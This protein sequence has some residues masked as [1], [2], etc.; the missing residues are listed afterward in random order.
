MKSEFTVSSKKKLSKGYKFD[1]FTNM[2][3]NQ[4]ILL[5][6][7]LIFLS[8]ISYLKVDAYTSIIYVNLNAKGL[9]NGK[10]WNDAFSDLQSALEKAESGDEIWVAAGVYKPT[11]SR[12][13]TL[14]FELENGVSIFGGFP[15]EGGDWD[16]RNWQQN[17]T[18]L[19]GD[20]GQTGNVSDNSYHVVTGNAS[21]DNSSILDGFTITSGNA[22]SDYPDNLGGGMYNTEGSPIL[23]N[24][25]FSENYAIHG[26]GMYNRKSE[27]IILENITFDSNAA[28]ERGG[29]IYNYSSRATLSGVLFKKNNAEELGG[30]MNNYDSHITLTDVDFIEN[31][32]LD[33]GGGVYSYATNIT[34]NRAN[35]LGNTAESGGGMMNSA[36]SNAVV[37]H[38]TFENNHA[39]ERAG[40][41]Y[42]YKSDPSFS[43]TTFKGNTAL[44]FGGGAMFNSASNTELTNVSFT[45]NSTDLYGGAIINSGG[46]PKLTNVSF[47][48]NSAQRGGGMYN[49]DRSKPIL[50]NV[51]FSMNTADSRGGG[52]YSADD[53][54]DFKLTDVTFSQNFAGEDG[55]G[56]FMGGSSPI[57]THVTFTENTSALHGGGFYNSGGS[58]TL[59][60][61]TFIDNKAVNGGGMNNRNGTPTLTDVTFS[62]NTAQERGGGIYN[63]LGSPKLS[64]INLTENY[65]GELGG[66]MFSSE[67]T[68][69]LFNVQISD[70]NAGSFGGG[71]Y[72]GGS[73]AIL[74]NITLS[75]NSAQERGGAI[76]NNGSDPNLTNVTISANAS[77]IGGG[78]YN[79]ENS[80]PTLTNVTLVHNSASVDGGGIYNSYS[81]AQIINSILWANKPN[82]ICGNQANV[83]YTIIQNAYAGIGN[84]HAN[85]LLDNLA[86]N[87]NFTLTHALLSGSPAIDA[88]NQKHCP[89]IDQRGVQRPQGAGCDI[90]AFE[91]GKAFTYPFV[92]SIT[93]LD[94]N[95][96]NAASVNFNVTF[97]EDVVGVNSTDFSIKAPL[98][99][100]TRIIAVNGTGASFTVTINTGTG[101]GTLTLEL[102]DDDSVKNSSGNPL[103]GVGPGNGDFTT[104]EAYTIN[105]DSLFI[106]VPTNH[107]AFEYIEGLFN[108][109]I[110]KGCETVPLSYCPNQN[111]T[112]AEMAVFLERSL[113]DA[114]YQ[115]PIG[116]GTV[117]SDVPST[118]WAVDWIEKLY[119]DEITSGCSI[120]P[121]RYCPDTSITRAE[122]A[123]L[124]LRS[125]YGIDYKPPTVVDSTGFDDVPAA[126]WAAAWIK[127]LAIEGITTGF[128][129]STFR[130][131]EPVT[132]A[133]MAVFLERIF[134][135]NIEPIIYPL[136]D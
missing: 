10:S 83:S 123:V 50:E 131:E 24:I 16:S 35:F 113:N 102:I 11:T 20:I 64:N 101:S 1:M 43:D 2:K 107:W 92:K 117:F 90:G 66:G 120:T 29:G 99:N 127:Q 37:T 116:L 41:V 97:S 28:S 86:D 115:P 48:R 134:F 65:A 54:C 25:V 129:D 73:D 38:A 12:D 36:N 72:N 84:I 47:S 55:G 100:E 4:I 77:E 93:I 135:L 69:N 121:L 110:T 125:K 96:T 79:S 22:N 51:L 91:F 3:K 80:N 62:N 5:T 42:N 33:R 112:R 17:I 103:G 68:P 88:A 26:G 109:G 40:A 34:I 74:A 19:S 78:I 45:E 30:G 32:S 81:T 60:N 75:K 52:M 39:L 18:I 111:V 44:N 89:Q 70:N 76:Y 27:N 122:M 95:P 82:S 67:S 124:L 71:I 63:Y 21:I 7:L 128:E 14:S 56:M 6:M 114:N 59:N 57:L 53:E 130:P 87:G 46:I 132:R 58:P 9:N 31:S 118:H 23:R 119:K 106:D 133:Q 15:V 104:G 13:R 49:F 126:H 105:K 136:I 8:G 94:P 61:V 85:P 108:S 98:L